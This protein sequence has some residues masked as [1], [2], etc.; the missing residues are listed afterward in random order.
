M[1]TAQLTREAI[2]SGFYRYGLFT[3]FGL[4]V[5]VFTSLNGNFFSAP[6]AINLLQ[7]TAS[8]GIAAAGLVFVLVSGGIDISMGSTIFLSSVV[9]TT[10]ANK[11]MGLAGAFAVAIGCGVVVGAVNGFLVAVLRVVPL[12][13]T[14]ASLYVVRG[15]ALSLTGVQSLFFFNDVGEAVAYARLGGVLPVVILILA[16]TL[17]V[18]QLVL[19]RTLFGRQLYAIGNNAAGARVMGIRVKSLTFLTYVISGGLAGLAGLV[20]GAQVGAI[21]PTFAEGQEFIIITSAILGGVS[22][23]GGKGTAFPGA[24]L[25]VLIVMCI[26]NG[27]VMAGANMYVYTIVRGLV[28]FFAVMLD[29]LRNTGELR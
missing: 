22:L 27:L 12:I 20:S 6:N 28:I 11:G 15:V 24:F 17:I 4:L 3:T 10:L 8:T 18:V 1:R 21:T 19:S 5:V 26:E 14:L 16:A 29:C 25:G 2:S 9:V 7:Q 13:V 23:F